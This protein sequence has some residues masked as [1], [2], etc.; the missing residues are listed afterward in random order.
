MS[1]PGGDVAA[2][3]TPWRRRAMFRLRRSCGGFRAPEARGLIAEAPRGAHSPHGGRGS[4]TSACKVARWAVSSLPSL[5][6]GLLVPGVGFKNAEFLRPHRLAEGLRRAGGGVR[7]GRWA[8]IGVFA[9][10]RG[11]W[12]APVGESVEK[13]CDWGRQRCGESTTCVAQKA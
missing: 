10:G 5:G 8:L 3:G 13:E 11:P 7:E 12:L 9:G 2:D 6:I 4:P 1:V